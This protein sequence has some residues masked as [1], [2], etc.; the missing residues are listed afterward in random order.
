MITRTITINGKKLKAKVATTPREEARG[1]MY[2]EVLGDDEAMLF[3]YPSERGLSFWMK[4]T[5]IPLSIAFIQKD[6]T[7]SE[8]R[9]MKPFD[10][11]SVKS[12]KPAKWALEVNQGWFSKNNV[13]VGDKINCHG[14]NIKL[15]IIKTT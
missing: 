3:E 15:T 11:D 8:I 9:D 14:R 1:L 4:N 5:K 6:G 12:A 13:K 7:V 10:L 2:D